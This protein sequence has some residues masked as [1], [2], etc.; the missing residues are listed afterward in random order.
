MLLAVTSWTY[1]QTTTIYLIRHAEKVDNSKN[2]DLSKA[3]LERAEHWN[4]VFAAVPLRA[5]YSTDYLRTVQTATPTATSKNLPIVKY[6]PKTIDIEKLKKEYAGQSILI[7]GHSN[8]TPDLANRIINESM[9]PAIDDSV[10]G[11]LYIITISDNQVSNQL[12]QS[13]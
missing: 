5:I 8:T 9:Y 11:N 2:P 1:S 13:L 4:A 6:D 3:G 12:L 10:F 7:V